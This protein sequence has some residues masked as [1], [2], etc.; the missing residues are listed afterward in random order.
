MWHRP[1]LEA[2][3]RWLRMFAVAYTV[4]T[5]F[6]EQTASTLASTDLECFQGSC[7]LKQLSGVLSNFSLA[8]GDVA[9]RGL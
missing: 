4:S 9:M 7:I 1:L 5:P 2:R 8:T 3:K 6:R